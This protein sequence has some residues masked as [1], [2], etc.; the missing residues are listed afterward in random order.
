M[1]ETRTDPLTLARIAA[2]TSRYTRTGTLTDAQRD[3]AVRELAELAAGR[4]DLLA[5][6]AGIALGFQDFR[7]GFEAAQYRL[8]AEMCIA[9]GADVSQLER[10][11]QAGHER[12]AQAS[13]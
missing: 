3:Q 7:Q 6:H 13:Q 2:V 1:G 11:R 12:A 8:A 4:T 5:Q 10:W 9:A